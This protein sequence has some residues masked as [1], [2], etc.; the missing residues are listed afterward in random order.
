MLRV[1]EKAGEQSNSCL[2]LKSNPKLKVGRHW[3]GLD[4]PW[5]WLF[6]LD[7]CITST[8]HI[9]QQFKIRVWFG[10]WVYQLKMMIS[11]PNQHLLITHDDYYTT[12]TWI[13]SIWS[14]YKT[15][16]MSLSLTWLYTC[17]NWSS[18]T[19]PSQAKGIEPVLIME[20]NPFFL[21]FDI[22]I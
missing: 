13:P 8:K 9:S 14:N 15:Q 18:P 21:S 16:P 12:C 5:W 17:H 3:I 6:R 1:G 11:H 19:K 7:F 22:I 20:L 4:R 2:V 10:V